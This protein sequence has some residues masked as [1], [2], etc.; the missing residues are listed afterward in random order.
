M[1]EFAPRMCVGASADS[2]LNHWFMGR[3]DVSNVAPELQPI[4]VVLMLNMSDQPGKQ[5][6][7]VV[8]VRSPHGGAHGMCSAEASAAVVLTQAC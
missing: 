4:L 1:S 7:F 8:H 3:L 2:G 5:P 6:C